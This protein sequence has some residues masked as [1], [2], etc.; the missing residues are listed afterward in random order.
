LPHRRDLR[1]AARDQRNRFLV[2]KGGTIQ[3]RDFD[4]NAVSLIFPE[5]GMGYY[6]PMPIRETRGRPW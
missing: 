2:S 3:L 5:D 4:A 1:E 6:C